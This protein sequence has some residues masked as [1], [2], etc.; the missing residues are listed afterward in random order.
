MSGRPNFLQRRRNFDTRRAFGAVSDRFSLCIR[1]SAIFLL[2]A[3]VLV[4][5]IFYSSLIVTMA[6]SG[7]LS[8]R[9]MGMGQTGDRRK[10]PLIKVSHLFQVGHLI[11]TA[12]CMQSGVCTSVA[13]VWLALLASRNLTSSEWF[14]CAAMYSGVKPF[15]TD[16]QT[17]MH[18]HTHEHLLSR[19]RSRDR[20]SAASYKWCWRWRCH[21]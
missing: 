6:L 7:L 19:D 13:S 21:L 15:Y 3:E 18:Y 4:T 2:S 10:T 17:D 16:T 8:F 9:D 11:S 1:I 12:W 20:S 14:S 5:P